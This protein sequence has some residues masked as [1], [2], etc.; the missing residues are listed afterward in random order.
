MQQQKLA[1]TE[2]KERKLNGLDRKIEISSNKVWCANFSFFQMVENSNYYNYCSKV[3][4]EENYL[5]SA[6]RSYFIDRLS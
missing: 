2:E 1:T 5:I 4:R 3:L 6:I